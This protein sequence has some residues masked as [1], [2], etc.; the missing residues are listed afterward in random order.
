MRA[1]GRAV[2][3]RA[4]GARH[5]SGRS[6]CGSQGRGSAAWECSLLLVFSRIALSCRVPEP[7]RSLVALTR[8]ARGVLPRGRFW[9]LASCFAMLRGRDV[10]LWR[11]GSSRVLSAEPRAHGPCRAKRG[12]RS[13]T[14]SILVLEPPCCPS[15][16]GFCMAH[17]GSRPGRVHMDAPQHSACGRGY[18]TQGKFQ[19]GRGLEWARSGGFEEAL[20]AMGFSE[21]GC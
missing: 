6:G 17:R 2:A 10:N 8:G 13:A 19:K 15:R 3:A 9:F 16:W 1:G 5:G 21:S 12:R 18:P 11:H 20:S 7:C 14:Q 4:G